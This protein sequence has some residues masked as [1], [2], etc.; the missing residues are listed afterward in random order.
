MRYKYFGYGF[1]LSSI[2]IQFTSTCIY[3]EWSIITLIKILAFFFGRVVIDWVF[4]VSFNAVIVLLLMVSNPMRMY[5]LVWSLVPI[6]FVHST[7]SIYVF[8]EYFFP[9]VACIPSSIVIYR[10]FRYFFFLFFFALTRR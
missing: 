3:K 6:M 10:C 4:L 1:I 8:H 7:L 5:L 9:Y 2:Y